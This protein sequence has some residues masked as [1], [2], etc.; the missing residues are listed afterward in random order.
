MS[1]ICK[2]AVILAAGY[3]SRLKSDIPKSVHSF[4]GKTLLEHNIDQ[5][6]RNNIENI[7]VVGGFK[8]DAISKVLDKY[9]KVKL[10]ENKDYLTT[11]STNTISKALPY[12]DDCFILIEADFLCEDRAI[13]ELCCSTSN[14]FITTQYTGYGDEAVAVFSNGKF[15]D[16][17][18]DPKF[19]SGN[20]QNPEYC[21]PSHL[22]KDMARLMVEYDKKMGG[23][24]NYY[25]TMAPVIEDNNISISM[26]YIP[27]LKWADLDYKED[28]IKIK[29]YLDN[30]LTS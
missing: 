6:I 14:S 2:N 5:L 29:Q 10:I 28:I 12:I 9:D 17:S 26:I 21:G 8:I 20:Q 18:K 16:V 19:R 15:I 25:S 11:G 24:L 23:N 13:K 3:G 30:N 4:N 27:R 1:H 7:F 22:S